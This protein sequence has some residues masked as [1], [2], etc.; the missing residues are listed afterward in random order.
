VSERKRIV[1]VGIGLVLL[2]ASLRVYGLFWG[3]PQVY[4][5]AT[6]LKK[7]WDIWGW[8]AGRSFDPN[9]HFFK[10]PSLVIYIH[11]LGQG[12]LY[13][14]L[15]AAGTIESILDYRTLNVVDKS[16][17]LIMGRSISTLLALGTVW[18][19]YLLGRRVGGA[20]TGITAALL[21]ALNTFHISR[22]QMV[23]VDVPL[24]FFV[25]MTFWRL[26]SFMEAPTRKNAV[27][28]GIAVGLAISSKY[29]GAF[30]ILPLVLA[31]LF[32]LSP[33][34]EKAGSR[35]PGE[36]RRHH[37]AIDL[38]LALLASGAVFLLTS[39]YVILD[40]GTFWRDLGQEHEH[41]SSG[42]FGLG[43]TSA[44]AFYAQAI[45]QR[46]LGWPLAIVAGVGLVYLSVFERRQWALCMA[47]FVLLYLAVVGSWTMKADRYLLPT[48]P[49]L[50]V[51]AGALLAS[52]PARLGLQKLRRSH[53]AAGAVLASLV[54][55]AGSFIGYP[56]MI[57]ARK[58]DSRTEATLWIEANL[59]TGTFI[60][61]EWLGPEFLT[62]IV[63]WQLEAEV[64]SRV[65]A[66]SGK[67]IYA[68]Q[69][70][71]MYQVSPERSSPYYDFRHYRDADLVITS[72]GVRSRY[73]KDPDRFPAQ[74]AF[75][76]TLDTVY[77]RLSEFKI[78]GGSSPTITVYKN[79][80]STRPFG[81]RKPVGSPV[82]LEN[83]TPDLLSGEEASLYYS[84][85]LNYETFNFHEQAL[86]AYTLGLR[87]PMIK[88][89]IF[90]SLAVSKTRVFLN[91]GRTDEALQFLNGVTLSAPTP[92]ARLRLN[93][94]RDG[95]LQRR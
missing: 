47:A 76:D 5:E 53:R 35:S 49:L 48:L 52:V 46:L 1:L 30:L 19:V 70:L 40:S 4:E 6:P 17:F 63:L 66:Q 62:P 82:V 90:L 69:M 34:T 27:L 25:V 94:I 54:L 28:S 22:S 13:L 3:L 37:P 95:L 14:L 81:G 93:Q 44:M 57:A 67:P 7:A 9:P 72:S 15:W 21:L 83:L 89:G 79:P 45:T 87:Y 91:L 33:K 36:G 31:W 26:V 12:L 29:T 71:P 84:L 38:G 10:Y 23:E 39:P 74:L 2:A 41:M 77:Q 92:H 18:L 56:G 86:E 16:A 75:Y 60:V 24:T 85:G 80:K 32:S 59:P 65:I 73:S 51:L 55:A 8:G 50:M 20:V 58:T 11:F 78:E 68:V 43:P 42:H 61:T 88:H 64:R